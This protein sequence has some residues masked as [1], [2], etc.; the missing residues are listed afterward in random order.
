MEQAWDHNYS[1]T[2]TGTTPGRSPYYPEV[3]PHATQR[4]A[5]ENTSPA[6]VQH[7]ATPLVNDTPSA[8]NFTDTEQMLLHQLEHN[9][10]DPA[11]HDA[12]H[13]VHHHHHHHHTQ[14]AHLHSNSQS[15]ENTPNSH[16]GH[17]SSSH[18]PQTANFD[19]TSLPLAPP[20]YEFG[21]ENMNFIIPE[22]LN[23]DTDPSHQSSAFPPSHVQPQTPAML[24]NKDK[25]KKVKQEG[26]DNYSSPVL[27]GQNEKSFNNQHYYHKHNKSRNLVSMDYSQP[28]QQH[29]RPDAV[30]TPL[31][32]PAVT[33]LDSQVN[34]NKNTNGSYSQAPVQVMFEPLTSPALE[35][36]QSGSNNERRRSS[37][38][39]FGPGDEHK[40]HSHYTHSN[41]RRTPHGTPVMSATP[42]TAPNGK[43]ISPSLKSNGSYRSSPANSGFEKLPDSSMESKSNG[44]TPMLPPQSK[45]MGISTSN[46]NNNNNNAPLMGFTMGR[47]AEH[48]QHE[49]DYSDDMEEK[50]RHSSTS[51][52][53]P[54]RKASYT[55]QRS[56]SSST[57]TSPK[58]RSNSDSLRKGDMPA[59]KKASHKLAEQ[60]RR[61]RMNTAVSELGSLVPQNYHD[62]VTIPSKATTVELASKYIRDLVDEINHLKKNRT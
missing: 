11:T 35:A 10:Y 49:D 27:P 41:K 24:A 54:R 33:P 19:Y 42:S 37:S 1:P 26:K 16:L 62:E 56:S 58:L 50:S 30:F 47:L 20:L 14:Q 25:S 29:V 36:Q 53:R 18:T 9:L 2:A 39:A 59:T 51:S 22:D 8:T 60:G 38:S 13:V 45:K 6:L 4:S 43:L 17:L 28:P 48:S 44:G 52:T 32:S 46:N 57:E 23:F 21:L 3:D 12:P 61:N 7:V 31:V 5:S 34:V 40:A 55:R 15:T